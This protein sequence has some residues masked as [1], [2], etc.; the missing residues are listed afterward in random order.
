ML[1]SAFTAVLRALPS[2][3]ARYWLSDCDQPKRPSNVRFFVGFQSKLGSTLIVSVN[4]SAPS[5]VSVSDAPVA[6][7]VVK[8]TIGSAPSTVWRPVPAV[9]LLVDVTK[10]NWRLSQ[11]A[12]YSE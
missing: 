12:W 4:L 7:V 1:P 5:P 9:V 6:L 8:L 2:A 10:R 3:M 11:Y